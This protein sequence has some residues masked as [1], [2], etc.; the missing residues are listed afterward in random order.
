[1]KG[2]KGESPPQILAPLPGIE[3]RK[4]IQRKMQS[5]T[6]TNPGTIAPKSSLGSIIEDIDGNTFLDFSAHVNAVGYNHPKVVSAIKSVISE[7]LGVSP[8]LTT[9][10]IECAEK[11]KSLLPGDLNKGK[12]AYTT[13]GSEAIDLGTRV[14]RGFTERKLIIS[15]HGTHYGEGTSD[16]SRLAGDYRPRYKGGLEPLISE[17][18]FAPYPYC[19]RCPLGHSLK[20]CDLD[21]LSYFEVIFNSF[22]P[23]D[24]A[25]VLI[26]GLPANSGILVPPSGYLQGLKSMCSENGIQLL[27]DEVYSGFG[28]T[29][30]MLAVENWN[31][32]PDI[33]CLGKSMGGGLPISAVVAPIEVIDQC[34]FLSLGTQGS[35][36]GNV[37]SCA[38]S[39]ATMDV[40]QEEQLFD[41]A[42]KSGKYMKQRLI[43]FAD[44]YDMIGDVRG[45]GLMLA[46]EMVKNRQTKVPARKVAETIRQK[47]YENGLLV[48]LVGQ[49]KNILRM[50]PHLVVTREQIEIGLDILENSIKSVSS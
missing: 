13:T 6:T 49:N 40:I 44:C 37:I 24:V 27:V 36:S 42:V 11:I 12:L 32:V 39:I 47:A 50:T 8:I 17:I 28:K 21:C 25:A 43:E 48:S 4:L 15:Y 45:V 2:N 23:N 31:I 29:G 38:A 5:F 22:S 20:G 10:F 3:T 30:K 1:M 35:F 7:L 26:E 14:A 46:L 41:K 16:C 34:D 33:V 9:P 19:Y 18:L